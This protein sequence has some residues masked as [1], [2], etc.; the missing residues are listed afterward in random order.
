MRFSGLGSPAPDA[1]W[2]R[3]MNDPLFPTGDLHRWTVDLWRAAGSGEREAT[4]VA[5]H[6]VGAN[7]A[8]HDSHG[9]GMTP[10]YVNALLEGDLQLNRQVE[11]VADSG[12]LLTL[13][14]QRG[15]GQSVAFQ[16]M[17]LAI[18]RAR[19]DGVCVMGLRNAH[20]IGRVGHWAE[21]GG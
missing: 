5:D 4:L 10:R 9:V 1:G 15:L 21:Q 13:D 20:H 6:L 11:V 18:G 16:A 17:E 8:G 14:G 19:R 2:R 12:T 3:H 7:L